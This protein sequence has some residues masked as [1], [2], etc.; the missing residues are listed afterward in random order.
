M[1][2]SYRGRMSSPYHHSKRD[3]KPG[4]FKFTPE[5]DQQLINL[6]NQYGTEDW[7]AIIEKMPWRNER[8]VRDRWF[9]YLSPDLNKGPWTEE[10]DQKLI[11]SVNEYGPSWVY[12]TQFFNGRTDV[13]IKNRWNVLSRKINQKNE[14]VE[15]PIKDIVEQ[16]HVQKIDDDIMKFDDLFKG[17]DFT[18]I[19]FM[20]ELL[21]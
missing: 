19:P 4:K 18:S 9:Y 5:E 1:S 15:S 6:V 8:Q 11:D 13:Q 20:S 3:K 12:I 14:V 21:F 16:E 17:I 10:E 7:L 2:Y